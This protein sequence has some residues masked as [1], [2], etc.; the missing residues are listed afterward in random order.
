MIT[1]SLGQVS[2]HWAPL[3]YRK[4]YGGIIIRF[5]KTHLCLED[6]TVRVENEG[7]TKGFDD[8]ERTVSW[9]VV[10]GDA[11]SASYGTMFCV[12]FKMNNWSKNVVEWMKKSNVITNV[13]DIQVSILHF[14]LF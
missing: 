12:Y 6:L 3:L 7:K 10:D 14:L 8:M 11:R 4:V 9:Q 13:L 1:G 2:H 5:T